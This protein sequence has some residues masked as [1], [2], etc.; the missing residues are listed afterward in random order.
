M[1]FELSRIKSATNLVEVYPNPKVENIPI[2]NIVFLITLYSPNTSF[3]KILA[4]NIPDN[5]ANPFPMTLPNRDQKES[6]N[7]RLDF[8]LFIKI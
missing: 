2:V 5:S 3:P 4:T 8:N 7:K 1:S 6:K